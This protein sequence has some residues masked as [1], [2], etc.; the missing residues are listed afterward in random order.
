MRFEPVHYGPAWAYTMRLGQDPNAIDLEMANATQKFMTFDP[1][2]LDPKYA[3]DKNASFAKAHDL[4]WA[5][6]TVGTLLG[7]FRLMTQACAI[8]VTAMHGYCS[9]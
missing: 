7:M 6:G 1:E 2:T 8:F 3:E 9:M 5:A 4:R